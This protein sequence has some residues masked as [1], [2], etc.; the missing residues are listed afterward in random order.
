[1]K[2]SHQKAK[3]IFFEGAV[4][5]LAS[6]RMQYNTTLSES[7]R[8]GKCGR[9]DMPLHTHTR[10][11][12]NSQLHTYSINRQLYIHRVLIVSSI[13]TVLIISSTHIRY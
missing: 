5:Q 4:K 3:N 8:K 13:H 10:Y 11:S 9:D 2:L 1:M 12:I 6:G 7:R